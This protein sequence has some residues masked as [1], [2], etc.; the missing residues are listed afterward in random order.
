MNTL[1]D[2]RTYALCA[3]VPYFARR[4][5]DEFSDQIEPSLLD[6][7]RIVSSELV[8]NAVEHSGR[9]LGDPITVKTGLKSNVL[10]VEVV[11]YGERVVTLK[12]QPSERS[13]LG[14]V[15]SGLGFVDELSDRWSAASASPFSVWA[16]IDVETK[17]L[18]RRRPAPP[19]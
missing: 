7:L 17:G 13:G 2:E 5:L 4:R 15:R 18:V 14:F 10:R 8:S 3:H 9:T 6:D 11:D 1:S 16:E 19:G 12:A